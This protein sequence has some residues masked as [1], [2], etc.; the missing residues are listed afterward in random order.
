MGRCARKGHNMRVITGTAKG[1]KLK[2][3]E[4]RDVRPT[5]DRVKEGLFSAIQFDIEGRRVLDLFAGSGQLGLEAL[6]RGAASALFID[7]SRTSADIVKSNV[8]LT[9]LQ[10][11]ATVFCADYSDFLATCR[12]QFDI[13]FLDPPYAA[14]ILVDA[15]QKC[16]RVM[17][18]YGVII[19]EHPCEQTLPDSAGGF[20]LCKQYK[21]GKIMLSFYRKEVT[22]V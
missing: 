3:L 19:C 9:G 20:A 7:K 13:A 16:V 4:G 17:S 14:G 21:Y 8:K 11:N 5:A 22:A 2:Q 10:E 6:S 18:D 12:E 15:L 1:R